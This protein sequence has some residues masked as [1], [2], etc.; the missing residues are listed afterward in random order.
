MCENVRSLPSQ[1]KNSRYG[2][3]THPTLTVFRRHFTDPS[4]PQI[5][6]ANAN[7]YFIEELIIPWGCLVGA[8]KFV[9]I[10]LGHQFVEIVAATVREG[11]LSTQSSHLSTQVKHKQPIVEEQV[12]RVGQDCK[13]SVRV[14]VVGHSLRG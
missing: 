10:F 1:T 9:K 6:N 3:V 2:P 8:I 5:C 7:I 11:T 14:P 12:R 13:F 4:L